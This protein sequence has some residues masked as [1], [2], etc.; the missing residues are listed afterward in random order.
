ME[1]NLSP[2]AKV[3]IERM[4]AKRRLFTRSI[5]SVIALIVITVILFSA[6]TVAYFSDKVKTN[7]VA[8]TAGNLDIELFEMMESGNGQV[9]YQDPLRVMPA[10]AVSKI[11]TVK[12]TGSLPVYVRIRIDKKIETA[13]EVPDDWKHLIECDFNTSDWTF[14]DG[15]YYYNEALA[16]GEVTEPLFQTVLFSAKMGNEFTNSTI[17]LVVTSEATQANGTGDSALTAVGWPAP[18]TTVQES[19]SETVAATESESETEVVDN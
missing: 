9:V 6:Q 12:N 15:Y 16:S 19:E 14:K 13:N 5:I 8:I 3:A 10:T 17:Y 2:E 7:E 18:A 4:K 11:V 1:Q